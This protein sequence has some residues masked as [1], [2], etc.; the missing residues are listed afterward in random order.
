MPKFLVEAKYTAAGTEGLLK[1]GAS[2]RRKVVEEL[3]ASMGGTLESFHFS[4]G[5]ADA[6][7]VIDLPSNELAL[8]I[9]LAVRASGMVHSAT[10][11]LLTVEEAD[12]AIERHANYRP[13]GA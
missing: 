11:P 5:N 1:S 4:F 3:V 12:R 7:I 9:A 10:T 6:V 2:Q 13:P 8:S